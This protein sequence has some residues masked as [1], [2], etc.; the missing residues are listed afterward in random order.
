LFSKIYIENVKTPCTKLYKQEK[1][2][3]QGSIFV[4]VSENNLYK[5]SIEHIP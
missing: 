4:N 5:S 2:W 3:K 1:E